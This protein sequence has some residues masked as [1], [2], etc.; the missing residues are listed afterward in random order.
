MYSIFC[1]C[2]DNNKNYGIYGLI[3]IISL[4]LFC[5]VFNDC[6][7]SVAQKF[8]VS[9]F[10]PPCSSASLGGR[11]YCPPLATPLCSATFFKRNIHGLQVILTYGKTEPGALFYHTL[12]YVQQSPYNSDVYT[13]R[14][15]TVSLA[16]CL[17]VAIRRPTCIVNSL[18]KLNT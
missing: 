12:Q 7:K 13:C 18:A 2:F 1:S 4:S 14:L 3:I 11:P 6:F 5:K 10:R 17:A 9:H 16:Q 15:Q 8:F